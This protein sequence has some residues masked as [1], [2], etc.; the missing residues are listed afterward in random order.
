MRRGLIP[1]P[2]DNARGRPTGQAPLQSPR[3][4]VAPAMAGGVRPEVPTS[5]AEASSFSP[6]GAFGIAVLTFYILFR[7]GMVHDVIGFRFGVNSHYSYFCIPVLVLLSLLG[8]RMP[9]IIGSTAGIWLVAYT[10]W[11]GASIPT[12]AWR[13]ASF[14]LFKDYLFN[15]FTIFV[16]IGCLGAGLAEQKRIMTAMAAALPIFTLIAL[17]TG[18]YSQTGRYALQFGTFGATND[19]AAHVLFLSP[20]VVFYM[21]E[22]ERFGFGRVASMATLLVGL[23]L[24]FRTGSRAGLLAMV[25]MLAV[26]FFWLSPTRKML[27]IASLVIAVPLML[28]LVPRASLV[29]YMT[30]F[31]NTAEIEAEGTAAGSLIAAEGSSEARK[32][33]LRKSIQTTLEHPILG[34]GAGQFIVASAEQA[35][36]AGKRASWRVT[37]NSYTQVSSELGV[38]GFVFYIG[39]LF[40]TGLHFISVRKSV[41][42]IPQ[43]RSIHRMASCLL[44]SWVAYC[45]FSAFGSFG[46]MQYVPM[47][48]AFAVSLKL[49]AKQALEDIRSAQPLHD[50]RA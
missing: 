16:I 15:D 33:L 31:S 36:E 27:A 48:A 13:G 35:K 10:I 4:W 7:M 34:V 25:L 2:V 3:R 44:V 21:L 24:M 20:F 30:M 18:I 47:L 42:G 28:P 1:T 9:K 19:M 32:E 14:L 6:L 41:T 23:M 40:T 29:R 11:I 26:V 22:R 38:P 43:L 37:H 46:Y 45:I 49:S 8:G 5:A 17:K 50:G 12:S 39:L